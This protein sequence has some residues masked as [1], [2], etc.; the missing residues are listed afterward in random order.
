M[1][2]DVF[3]PGAL[4]RRLVLEA[5][6]ETNDGSGGVTRSFAAAATLW[7]AVEPVSARE[8]VAAD[9]LGANVTHRI[10]IRT[11]ADVTL[12]HRFRDGDI[13]FRIVA[14]RDR[15]RRFL[16]IDAEQRAD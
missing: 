3:D 15:D 5:P 7:A 11:R 8:S 1:S 4:N 6:V 14:I 10:R 9:A 16:D 12:R 13:V 2:G